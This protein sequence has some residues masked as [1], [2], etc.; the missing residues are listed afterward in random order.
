[1]LQAIYQ[2]PTA[3]PDILLIVDDDTSVDVKKMKQLMLNQRDGAIP[4]I[5]APCAFKMNTRRAMIMNM[6][7]FVTPANALNSALNS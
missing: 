4:F 3:I 2:N 6:T 7:L 1:M 5:G